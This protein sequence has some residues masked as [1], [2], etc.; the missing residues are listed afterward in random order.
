MPSALML[1]VTKS[2]PP[3]RPG[4]HAPAEVPDRLDERGEH[5][6]RVRRRELG[7][8]RVAVSNGERA[9]QR[10]AVRERACWTR[11]TSSS[12]Q[13]KTDCPSL[14]S[15][16]PSQR[17]CTRRPRR[18]SLARQREWRRRSRLFQVVRRARQVELE[19]LFG[20]GLTVHGDPA[21]AHARGQ[22][23][24]ET[25]NEGR[26]LAAPALHELVDVVHRLHLGHAV[27]NQRRLLLHAGH[28]H[29]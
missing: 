24:A 7:L 2:A 28:T 14:G 3:T 11:M 8:C 6:G 15:M 27:H 20:R 25:H 4:A 5:H 22:P 29:A 12:V 17:S 13:P 16:E 1:P 10:G 19:R 23:R 18:W 9:A 26:G 21:P